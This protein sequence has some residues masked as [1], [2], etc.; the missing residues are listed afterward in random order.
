[1]ILSALTLIGTL[2]SDIL[3]AWLDPRIREAI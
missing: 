3:L 2:L 1:L